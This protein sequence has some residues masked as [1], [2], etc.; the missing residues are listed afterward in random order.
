MQYI[1]LTMT[2]LDKTTDV[3]IK[4]VYKNFEDKGRTLGK[5]TIKTKDKIKTL[6]ITPSEI[7]KFEEQ[8]KSINDFT[9]QLVNDFKIES[10]ATEELNEN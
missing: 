1:K 3:K 10:I 2:F 9:T 6:T 4:D 5:L 8:E 7:E